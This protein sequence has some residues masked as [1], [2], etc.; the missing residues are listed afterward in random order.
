MLGALPLLHGYE[1]HVGQEGLF[2]P[3]SANSLNSAQH[4]SVLTESPLGFFHLPC[5]L[6][7]GI[8]EQKAT[9]E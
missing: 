7:P 4:S 8:S 5:R 9:E 3:H 1:L 6:L 2:L